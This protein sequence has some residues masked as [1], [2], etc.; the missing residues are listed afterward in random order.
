MN[1]RNRKMFR[2]KNAGKQASGILASSPQ[3]MQTVQKRNLGGINARTPLPDPVIQGLIAQKQIERKQREL[4]NSLG[5]S[6][7]TSQGFKLFPGAPPQ[8]KPGNILSAIGNIFRPLPQFRSE[9]DAPESLAEGVPGIGTGGRGIESL[10][11]ASLYRPSLGTGTP[12]LPNE[13]DIADRDDFALAE[14]ELDIEDADTGELE[15]LAS[16]SLEQTRIDSVGPTSRPEEIPERKG[17][18]QKTKPV[19]GTPTKATEAADAILIKRENQS[20]QDKKSVVNASA[21]EIIQQSINEALQTQNNPDVSPKGKAEKTDELLGIIKTTDEPTRKERI[22]ARKAML[23]ELLGEDAAKDI[24]TD[25]NYNLMMTGLLIAAGESPNALANIAKGAAAGLSKYG[26]V[27]GDKAVKKREREEKIALQAISDIKDEIA[28][29]DKRE[30]DSLVRSAQQEHELKLQDNKYINDLKLLERKLTEEEQRQIREHDLKIQ[31]ANQNVQQTFA[32]F[33]LQ[34]EQK[35]RLL[36]IEMSFKKELQQLAN[37]AD[38]AD[39]K[40]VKALQLADP[41]LTFADA[42]AKFKAT[43]AKTPTDEQQRYL[44]FLP[45]VGEEKALIYAQ[46]GVSAEIIDQ[47]G[48]KKG[49]KELGGDGTGTSAESSEQTQQDQGAS[50]NTY[51]VGQT[52]TQEGNRFEI[53][54]VDA[55]G[56]ITATK[57]L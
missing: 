30:Y 44:R 32:L 21:P 43:T 47:L 25:A 9:P 50:P 28:T 36:D 49:M 29:E 37:N 55:Q 11:N 54:A 13:F 24:R 20:N 17:R 12:P 35:T 40:M 22:E 53:T 26:D 16:E 19:N 46:S 15:Q 38:S 27:V 42:Y 33:D 34:D 8:R 45:L 14:T 10:G 2:P 39:M 48:F 1:P 41:T 6:T 23:T 57:E 51:T 7:P 5:G 18:N 4:A 52:I 3:L 31:L 56:N